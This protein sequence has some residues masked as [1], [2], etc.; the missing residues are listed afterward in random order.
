MLGYRHAFHAGNLGDVVK[1]LALLAT[2]QACQRKATPLLYAETHA[3]GGRYRFMQSTSSTVA[4]EF[5]TGVG[6]LWQ[7][8][9]RIDDPLLTSYLRAVLENQPSA[10]S[11]GLRYYPGSPLLAARTL[12]DQDRLVLAEL[13]SSEAPH[14]RRLF[15]RDSRVRVLHA[16]GYAT[17]RSV[18]PP[19]ER[20]GVVLIDP[21]YELAGEDDRAVAAIADGRRRFG[22]GV[23]LL[24]APL[25]GKARAE[26]MER[27]LMGLGVT[28]LLRVALSPRVE[29]AA[30]GSLVWLL[31][32]PYLVDRVLRAALT[33]A[34]AHLDAHSEVR[35][36]A[37]G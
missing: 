18:L 2:L 8:R 19:P 13:H 6:A 24:W 17:L 11:A 16:D 20:R 34:A 37:G 23:F 35:W 25:R 26:R 28:N 33:A 21:A 1:H 29:D 30:L 36:L 7:A 32:P 27:T 4:P 22:N 15:A 9:E 5:S 31:S 12:R 10:E 3:G 14:L